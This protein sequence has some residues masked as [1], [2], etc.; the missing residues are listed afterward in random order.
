M[1][2]TENPYREKAKQV[3]IH[4]KMEKGKKEVMKYPKVILK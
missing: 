3:S 2:L 1:I 4:L